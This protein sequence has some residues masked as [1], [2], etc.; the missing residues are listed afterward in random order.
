MSIV[1]LILLAVLP[2]QVESA[3][4]T[5]LVNGEEVGTEEFTIEQSGDGFLARGR[6]RLE[7]DG[8]TIDVQSRMELD[9]DLNPISYEYRS[10]ERVVR[11]EITDLF[12][13]VQIIADGQTTPY[14]IRFPSDG[15][16]IDDNFFHHYLLLLYR[17]GDLG[18]IL[19]VFVPQ[20][21]TLGSLQVRP[22]GDRTF[23]LE[24]Q[25]L[26]LR[27]TTDEDGRMIRLVL[28]DSDVVVER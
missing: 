21:M 16:I 27:A 13:E 12:T 1:S 3:R 19:P 25:N 22:A 8:Q 15:V 10:A 7:V 18:G 5:I 26:R 11:M 24:S 23:E 9:G 14:D 17:V 4:F 2:V 28:L 6:T 20:Q